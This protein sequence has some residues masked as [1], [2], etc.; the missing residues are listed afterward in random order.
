MEVMSP[1]HTFQD[2]I[3]AARN[4]SNGSDKYVTGLT[5]HG[6]GLGDDWPLVTGGSVAGGTGD[7]MSRPIEENTAFVVKPGVRP[8]NST[9]RGEGLTW[10]DTVR[11]T[12]TGA[13]RMGK[14][15]RALISVQ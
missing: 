8:K 7:I 14:R 9:Y 10:A 11:V 3:D 5:L 12:A 1:G 15:E 4:A 6:R 2:V 13:Q